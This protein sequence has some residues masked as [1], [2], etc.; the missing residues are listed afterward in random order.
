MSNVLLEGVSTLLSQLVH[1]LDAPEA[2]PRAERLLQHCLRIVGARMAGGLHSQAAVVEAT[3]RRLV[4]AGRASDALTYSELHQRLSRSEHGLHQL[5]AAL[6]LL[7]A[8]LDSGATP[9]GPAGAT[10]ALLARAAAP[11][12]PRS[13]ATGATRAPEPNPTSSEGTELAAVTNGDS[14]IAKSKNERKGRWQVCSSDGDVSEATLVR[15]LLFVMQSIDG[16]HL[17]FDEP[18]DGFVLPSG[19]KVPTGARQLVGRLAELGWLFRQISSYV[20]AGAAARESGATAG[21]PVRAEG[22][23]VAQALR[24]ALQAE[25]DEWCACVPAPVTPRRPHSARPPC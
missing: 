12:P 13:L 2:D 1:Q 15:E 7:T 10:A 14:A 21:E 8:L 17:K 18:R 23:L 25:L 24:H 20:K 9:L 19:T 3:R 5:P 11:G 4:Q 22:G 16:A 6:Q